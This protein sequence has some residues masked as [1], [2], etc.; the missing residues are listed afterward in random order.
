MAHCDHFC[1]P[2]VINFFISSCY[3]IAHS[4][5]NRYV[6]NKL[7]QMSEDFQR[8]SVAWITQVLRLL[9][10]CRSVVF[11]PMVFMS[12]LFSIFFFAFYRNGSIVQFHVMFDGEKFNNAYQEWFWAVVRFL[13]VVSYAVYPIISHILNGVKSFIGETR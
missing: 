12:L 5:T 11:K 9:H 6:V 10:F 2:V 1:V 4:P 8:Y 7:E 3:F 13:F